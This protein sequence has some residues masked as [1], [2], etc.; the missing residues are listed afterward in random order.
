M[1]YGLALQASWVIAVAC[2]M[3]ETVQIIDRSEECEVWHAD[4]DGDGFGDPGVGVVGC[5]EPEG[6]VFDD[7]DCDDA[8]PD[9]HPG[10]VESCDDADQDC[11]G[12]PDNDAIDAVLWMVDADGDH[13]GDDETAIWSCDA[14]PGTVRTGGDPDDEDPGRGAD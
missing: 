4:A 12:R 2:P 13:F 11:D 6:H 5:L 1:R 7:T 9:T 14:I 3:D 10:A 8:D